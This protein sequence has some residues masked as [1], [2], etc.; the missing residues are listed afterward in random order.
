[1]TVTLR[2]DARGV[3]PLVEIEGGLKSGGRP[4][5][6]TQLCGQCA[7]ACD[8]SERFFL[9]T[10]AS[11]PVGRFGWGFAMAQHELRTLRGSGPRAPGL[12]TVQ[13]AAGVLIAIVM[14]SFLRRLFV[15]APN[16]A[17][18]TLPPEEFDR[19]YVTHPWLA[20]LHI[21]PGVLYLLVAPLQLAYRFRRRHYTFHRRLGRL[22][23]GLAIVSGIL[24]LVFGGLFA[25]GGPPEASAAIVFGLWFVVCLVLAVRAIRR[26]D[27]VHH[28][29][30]MIRAFA[31]GVAVGTVR[32]WLAIFQATGLLDSQSSFGP[33]FWAG[34]SLHAVAAELWLRAFPDPPEISHSTPQARRSAV[35]PS[36]SV[37]GS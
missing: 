32:V 8:F 1:M 17:A 36:T 18:G 6:H 13:I 23:A 10:L 16:L 25:F 15:D 22:L 3:C 4:G 5:L 21:V 7:G 27:I 20:Y 30:W 26:G 2:R 28:R 14:V 9:A 11:V 37:N 34:F 29:R 33:A 24:A 31:T 35:S 19:R 12:R